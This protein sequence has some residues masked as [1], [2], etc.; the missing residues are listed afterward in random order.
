MNKS[1]HLHTA[2]KRYKKQDCI[3]SKCSR[4]RLLEY[5]LP[6]AS[7]ED[8]NKNQGSLGQN[9]LSYVF[10]AF[11]DVLRCTH[12]YLVDVVNFSFLEIKL[13]HMW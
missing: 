7:Q 5:N 1:A 4:A 9:Y 10:V 13:T 12:N 2:L 3:P 11:L 6:W 8:F